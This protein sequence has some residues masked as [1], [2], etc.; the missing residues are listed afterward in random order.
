M[1]PTLRRTTATGFLWLLFQGLSGRL[2]SFFSQIVL[3]RLL[4]PEGVRPDRP[5]LHGHSTRHRRRWLRHRRRAAHPVAPHPAVGGACFL[6]QPGTR[7]CRHGRDAGSRPHRGAPLPRS[8]PYRTD[9][10]PGHQ[11]AARCRVH[12]TG[13]EAAGR[14]GFPLSG[15]LRHHRDGGHSGGHHCVCRRGPGRLQ[16]R[17]TVAVRG[18]HQGCHLLVEGTAAHPARPPDAAIPPPGRQRAAGAEHAADDRGS[19][20]GRLHRTG[21]AGISERGG[22]VFLCLPPGRPAVADARGQLRRRA[23]SGIPPAGW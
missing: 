13:G 4:M 6:E 17:S 16:L 22:R 19:Q 11:P 18:R 10:R 1:Q 5:G 8:G 7:L 2:S 15:H 3:A 21:P 12:R 23:V 9:R 20:P 14:A